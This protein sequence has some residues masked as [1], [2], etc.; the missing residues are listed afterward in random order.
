MA[1]IDY[2]NAPLE[3]RWEK[4]VAKYNSV[5]G[6]ML[7]KGFFAGI[8]KAVTF[9]DLKEDAQLLEVGCG[10]GQ[11]SLQIMKMLV[12]QQ[13]LQISDINKEFVIKLQ[14][15][16]FPLR[17]TQESV[18][19]L[20]RAGGEFDCIFLLEVLEHLDNYEKALSELV[21]VSKKYIVISVPNEPLW[22]ILNM[23]RGKYLRGFGNT[24]TH[25]NH[26]S[27]PAL[28]KL[29]SQY[30]EVQKIYLP[31]PWIILVARLYQDQTSVSN[32]SD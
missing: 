14:A 31:I 15:S 24:P 27:P 5:L 10:S 30:A 9:M 28:K 6:K 18:Y 4:H 11:G 17:V 26:W 3:G 25:V 29:V 22:R 21:R 7:L 8:S 32:R 23:M 19:D 20:K 12:G 13:T 16:N 1:K 2:A